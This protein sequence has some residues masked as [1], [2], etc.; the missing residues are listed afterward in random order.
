[1][2]QKT[3]PCHS[4]KAY[5]DCCEPF[6]TQQKLPATA[7]ELMRSRYS[8]YAL[9]LV[10]YLIDTTHPSNDLFLQPKKKIQ[11]DILHFC[12]NTQFYGLDIVECIDG[13]KEA[14]V[15]FR[16]G[17]KQGAND[18]SFQEKSLFRKEKGRWSY[19]KASQIS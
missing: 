4:G 10:A 3:C 16:A 12:L 6:H 9:G 13:D 18:I 2:V 15:T 8:A 17:L 5:R 1:M 19:V 11:E 7:L 14:Y